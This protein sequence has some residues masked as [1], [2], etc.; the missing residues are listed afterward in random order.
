MRTHHG[1]C[2]QKGPGALA[3]FEAVSSWHAPSRRE[4]QTQAANPKAPCTDMVVTWALKGLLYHDFG[5]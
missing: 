4:C 5:A 3:E 1:V 2:L